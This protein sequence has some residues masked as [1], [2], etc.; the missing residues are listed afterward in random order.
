MNFAWLV[1]RNVV[2][3]LR[4]RGVRGRKSGLGMKDL[5]NVN[6]DFVPEGELYDPS[7]TKT[8]HLDDMNKKIPVYKIYDLREK[9]I[10]KI[11]S[12]LSCRLI[13]I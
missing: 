9:T 13:V 6:F 10:R 7:H 1:L 3:A 11:F 8:D 12:F 4:W 2:T 5:S